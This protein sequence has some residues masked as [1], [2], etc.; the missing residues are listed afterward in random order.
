MNML[1]MHLST[2]E[3]CFLTAAIFFIIVSSIAQVINS[4]LG[5]RKN[6]R[7]KDRTKH[8]LV[9]DSNGVATLSPQNE[10]EKNIPQS[11][12]EKES[13]GVI[14][15]EEKQNEVSS[16]PHVPSHYQAVLYP[17]FDRVR[18]IVQS[19]T[20]QGWDTHFETLDVP[21]KV[22]SA[23]PDFKAYRFRDSF[24]PHAGA[25]PTCQALLVQR[26]FP[27][28]AEHV[29]ALLGDRTQRRKWDRNIKT[30]ES[31]E[32]FG[33]P[34][35]PGP[36]SSIIEDGVAYVATKSQGPVASRGMV[37][38]NVSEV[39]SKEDAVTEGGKR[40]G[41]FRVI[42]Q[43][44]S[45]HQKDPGT[46]EDVRI[47]GCVVTFVERDVSDPKNKCILTY[48]NAVNLK[49]SLWLPFDVFN[50][51]ATQITPKILYRLEKLIADQQE[52]LI[53]VFGSSLSGDNLPVAAA[54]SNVVPA[55]TSSSSSGSSRTQG[56]PILSRLDTIEK[57]L[58]SIEKRVGK[59]KTVGSFDQLL[60]DVEPYMVTV[61][62]VISILEFIHRKR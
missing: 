20:N 58:A 24:A 21:A 43:N 13:N 54:S 59:S 26:P 31:L 4:G 25:D 29:T 61:V 5:S 22:T 45:D 46:S 50:I 55:L 51:L 10:E 38:V 49:L 12:K 47:E 11:S 34:D 41:G 57:R 30:L 18:E 40:Y 35:I 42:T 33:P 9:R 60:N 7:R 62:C 27:F 3:I 15:L 56:N 39:L 32:S 16:P 36:M 52:R 6:K 2:A 28:P 17:L 37:I 23:C 14:D 53:E 19:S 8:A 48:F 1:T 44:I